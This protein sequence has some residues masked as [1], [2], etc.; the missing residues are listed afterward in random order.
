MS[1]TLTAPNI[2]VLDLYTYRIGHQ[3]MDYSYGVA[4]SVVKSIVSITL[5]L[6][7][8]MVAKKIRGKAVI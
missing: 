4:I 7:A 6:A 1:N 8:N 5:V 3:N 2:E